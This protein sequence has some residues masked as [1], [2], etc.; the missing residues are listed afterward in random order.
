[1]QR[2]FVHRTGVEPNE[3]VKIYL[4]QELTKATRNIKSFVFK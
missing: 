1:M 3:C 2:Y 4:E